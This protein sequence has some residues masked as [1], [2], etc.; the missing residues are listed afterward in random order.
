MNRVQKKTWS[1]MRW[2]FA[3]GRGLVHL[4]QIIGIIACGSTI[5]FFPIAEA[6]TAK[7]VLAKTLK[8]G[9]VIDYRKCQVDR[10]ACICAP[11][12]LPQT[13]FGPKGVRFYQCLRA[14]CGP[15]EQVLISRSAGGKRTTT[16]KKIAIR[17]YAEPKIIKQTVQGAN[18]KKGNR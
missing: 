11:G 17:E 2:R 10:K 5:S 7:T 3:K 8:E 14:N 13:F 1:G 4:F 18:P 6:K 12:L 15:G 9:D 16:C